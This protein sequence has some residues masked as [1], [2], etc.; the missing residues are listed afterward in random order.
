[1]AMITG[2]TDAL[3]AA[4]EVAGLAPLTWKIMFEG[5]VLLEGTHVGGVT[6]PDGQL[7]CENWGNFLGIDESSDLT[8]DGCRYWYGNLEDWTISLYSIHDAALYSTHYPDDPAGF[9]VSNSN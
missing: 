7:L 3:N 6:H 1:M 4:G 5:D 8:G 2:I 9:P